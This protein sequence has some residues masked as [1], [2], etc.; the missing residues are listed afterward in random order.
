M[1]RLAKRT[2]WGRP[3]RLRM[4]VGRKNSS[5]PDPAAMDRA[6]LIQTILHMRCDFPLDFTE[7]YL[8]KLS[9][10]KLRHIYAALLAHDSRDGSAPQAQQSPSA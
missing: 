6:A 9:L 4:G 1:A 10:E 5:Y 7:Q 8:R 3:R 2:E